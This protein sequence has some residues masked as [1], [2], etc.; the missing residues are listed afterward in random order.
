M[1]HLL[2]ELIFIICRDI[3]VWRKLKR[4]SKRMYKLL[5]CYYDTHPTELMYFPS[6]CKDDD[7][8]SLNDITRVPMHLDDVLH[9]IS[10]MR[11]HMQMIGLN[12]I[13]ITD[14]VIKDNDGTYHM[15]FPD[16]IQ[17]YHDDDNM[18]T[19]Y[20][21]CVRIEIPYEHKYCLMFGDD[22]IIIDN[23]ATRETLV[24]CRSADEIANGFLSDIARFT[25]YAIIERFS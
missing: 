11:K 22:D 24:V 13:Y 9:I 8:V 4:V 17:L 14:E 1:D 16:V 5:R 18:V 2:D 10:L 25:I 23:E 15:K 21:D 7:H 19:V 3:R 12:S 20:V 6:K